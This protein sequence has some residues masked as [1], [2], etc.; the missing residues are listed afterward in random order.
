MANE[1]LHYSDD[2]SHNNSRANETSAGE[3]VAAC[4]VQTGEGFVRMR[5]GSVSFRLASAFVRVDFLSFPRFISNSNC[6]NVCR[7]Y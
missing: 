3:G 5:I 4:P 6:L 7:V 1:S 2:S